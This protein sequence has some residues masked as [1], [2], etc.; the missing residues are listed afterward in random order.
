LPTQDFPIEGAKTSLNDIYE[1]HWHSKIER[2][3]WEHIPRDECLTYV[4]HK[5]ITL[6]IARRLAVLLDVPLV[7]FIL[8]LGL[9]TSRSITHSWPNDTEILFKAQRR[10]LSSLELIRIETSLKRQLKASHA[11]DEAPSLA[12]IAKTLGCSTGGLEYHFPN[13]CDQ[14]IALRTEQQ[15]AKRIEQFKLAHH[16]AF[17]IIAENPHMGRK[18]LIRKLRQQHRLPVHILR[19]AIQIERVTPN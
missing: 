14:L 2:V 17:K 8:G 4:D 19:K 7:D 11:G 1:A 16:Q 18:K 6:L 3:L 12:A 9:Y 15:A 5:P 10:T 13:L